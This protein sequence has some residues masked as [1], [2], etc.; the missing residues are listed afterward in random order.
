MVIAG[1]EAVVIIVLLVWLTEVVNPDGEGLE[2]MRE[3]A[4][5]AFATDALENDFG[6]GDMVRVYTPPPTELAVI[7]VM[8]TLDVP[9]GPLAVVV[10]PVESVTNDPVELLPLGWVDVLV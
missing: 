4:G 9:D 5:L 2:L 3:D 8:V 1:P 7:A 10:G 6:V